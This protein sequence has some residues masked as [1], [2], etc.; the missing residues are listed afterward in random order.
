MLTLS[1]K[2]SKSRKPKAD[3]FA[4]ANRIAAGAEDGSFVLPRPARRLVRFIV[5]LCTGKV[6]LPRHIGKASLAAYV[7][8]VGGYGVV[9]GGYWPQF[10]ET[11]TSSAGFAV[12]NVKLAGNVHISEIDVLQSLGLDGATSLVSLDVDDARRRVASLPWVASVDIRKVYPRTILLN[13]KERKPFGIWQH[14]SDL[15]LIEE[16]GNIIAPLRDNKFASLPLFV[17]RDA[18]TDAKDVMAEF[19]AF[20]Q[21]AARVKA[22]VRVSS[23]R[24]DLYLDNGVTVKLPEDDVGD[25]LKRLVR[26]ETEQQL[27]ERDIAAVDLR[28]A[29]R[30]TVELTPDALARRNAAVAAR[31]KAM[32]KLE[33]ET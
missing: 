11:M 26:M 24:W 6:E 7:L 17:G 14:G 3:R 16:N 2:K 23:R 21:V 13:I 10:S 28:L 25:A 1:A 20:P 4:S 15:S 19:A 9:H 32:A 31:T 27:L 30:M 12:D 33:K 22:Y 18:D 29:D 8:A 5:S